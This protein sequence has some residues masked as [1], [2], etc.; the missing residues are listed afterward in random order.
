MKYETLNK[1]LKRQARHLFKKQKQINPTIKLN[2]LFFT[3]EYDN[4]FSLIPTL[5]IKKEKGES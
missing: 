4:P 2:D 5:Y 3:C 1:H